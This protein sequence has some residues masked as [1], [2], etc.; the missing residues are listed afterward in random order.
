MAKAKTIKLDKDKI[1]K[2]L[3]QISQNFETGKWLF[4]YNKEL[5]Q[6]YFGKKIIPKNSF[7]YNLNDEINIFVT[8][9]STINGIFIE[10]FETNYIKHN[11]NLKHVIKV[12]VNEKI[13]KDSEKNKLAQEALEEKIANQALISVYNKKQLIA[14]V[15]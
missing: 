8:P 4:E 15:S 14:A 7:L 2:Q 11:K 1:V 6:L 5:D 3:G 12:L 9:K 13:K 10:Y